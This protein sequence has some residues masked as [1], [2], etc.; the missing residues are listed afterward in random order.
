MEP[1]TITVHA[2]MDF[3]SP[4]DAA[5]SLIGAGSAHHQDSGSSGLEDT[6][7][8]RD[9]ILEQPTSS[10]SMD[11]TA[12]TLHSNRDPIHG[13]GVVLVTHETITSMVRVETKLA[14]VLAVEF[15][16]MAKAALDQILAS[17]NHG[18]AKQ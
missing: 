10:T 15:P 11:P 16:W 4:D 13:D 14:R 2:E 6:S 8:G 12:H 18:I 7:Q 1:P 3:S 9:A 17:V 5:P